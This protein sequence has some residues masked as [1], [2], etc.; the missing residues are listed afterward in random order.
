MKEGFGLKSIF[1]SL[2]VLLSCF[3]T[4]PHKAFAQISPNNPFDYK[5][6]P[7]CADERQNNPTHMRFYGN[8]YCG[9][10]NAQKEGFLTVMGEYEGRITYELFDKNDW[11]DIPPHDLDI[12]FEFDERTIAPTTVLGCQY[13]HV[14]ATEPGQL[15]YQAGMREII[16]YLL[17]GVTPPPTTTPRPTFTP[18]PT[19]TLTL[20]LYF[21]N[22][23][24][25]V[26]DTRVFNGIIDLFYKDEDGNWEQF[27]NLVPIAKVNGVWNNAELENS[28]ITKEVLVD[29]PEL[30]KVKYQFSPF[31]NGAL[32]YLLME[33]EADKP[34]IKMTAI[35]NEVSATIQAFSIGNYYGY[36]HL[37][38]YIKI[39]DQIYDAFD[40]LQPSGGN[41]E[42]GDFYELPAPENK[43]I[44]FWGEGEIEQKQFVEQPISDQDVVMVEV[45]YTPWLPEQPP[46][47]RNWFET[48]HVTREPFTTD[49]AVFHFGITPG[50]YP[51]VF[52]LK[53]GWNEIVWPN[54]P[55]YTGQ[56]ALGG[57]DQDCGSGT[58]LVIAK[59][60][61]DFWQ[62]YVSGHGGW[63]FGIQSS[64][65]YFIK[66]GRDCSWSP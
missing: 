40:Y 11:D 61:Q 50:R 20:P 64:Q 26:W 60:E 37:V 15:G 41:Y 18:T 9:G 48:V 2:I 54:V 6:I 16:D 19:P 8:R 43:E 39:N 21:E 66:A 7:S 62:E 56:S 32:F 14:G 23:Y 27:N 42:L 34:F 36:T 63:D 5:E 38:R 35:P 25:R 58:G 59:K 17:A 44:L 33:M 46:P 24:L 51:T 55:G 28:I 57:I 3:L 53:T 1:I 29:T 31:S 47:G 45:R 65:V 22:Q 4:I 12:W 52:K 49:K 30:Q 13:Y 10:C